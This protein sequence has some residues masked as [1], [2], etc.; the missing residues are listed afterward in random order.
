MGLIG[1]KV[2]D[3][4]LFSHLGELKS[5][6]EINLIQVFSSENCL[7]IQ[8]HQ[9][10]QNPQV[11]QS[12]ALALPS[13]SHKRLFLCFCLS[14]AQE[15]P[16]PFAWSSP[17]WLSSHFRKCLI[18]YLRC[19]ILTRLLGHMLQTYTCKPKLVALTLALPVETLILSFRLSCSSCS[20]L[21][22]FQIADSHPHHL[23]MVFTVFLEKL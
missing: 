3:R 17:V 10:R 14:Q 16:L 19:S 4:F 18:L 11:K 15:P 12:K 1:A 5:H 21:L 8:A 20:D 2:L 23:D 13:Q 22:Y 7:L 9:F 6:K